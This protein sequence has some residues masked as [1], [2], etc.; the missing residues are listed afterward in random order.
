MFMHN[1]WGCAERS[2]KL[3]QTFGQKIAVLEPSHFCFQMF[4]EFILKPRSFSME[5]G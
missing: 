4:K 1:Y 2:S 5:Y 3:C